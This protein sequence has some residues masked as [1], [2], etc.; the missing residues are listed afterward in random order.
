MTFSLWSIFLTLMVLYIFNT[1]ENYWT[2]SKMDTEHVPWFFHCSIQNGMLSV[3]RG[4][5]LVFSSNDG[6]SLFNWF[7]PT[8]SLELPFQ[9]VALGQ[10]SLITRF[11]SLQNVGGHDRP[12]KNDQMEQLEVV[13]MVMVMVEEAVETLTCFFLRLNWMNGKKCC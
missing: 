1:K 5:F 13:V 4:P 6:Q 2:W 8:F 10:S 12:A 11:N 7:S 9:W 3:R